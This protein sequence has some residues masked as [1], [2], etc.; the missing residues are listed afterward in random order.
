LI[1][2][3]RERN[4]NTKNITN[5]IYYSAYLFLFSETEIK[6]GQKTKSLTSNTEVSVPGTL[7][8]KCW[9]L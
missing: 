2:L 6:N 4:E 1:D 7:S 3:M 9:M 5:S 8:C